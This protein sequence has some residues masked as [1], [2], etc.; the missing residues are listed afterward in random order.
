MSKLRD[1]PSLPSVSSCDVDLL[2]PSR[3]DETEMLQ[4]MGI[5]VQRVVLK[6]C[7]FFQDNI[8]QSS[9]AHIKHPYSSEMSLKS[10]VVSS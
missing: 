6:H 8:S 3:N 9:I 5:L 4:N 1:I 10:E 7:K 2:L